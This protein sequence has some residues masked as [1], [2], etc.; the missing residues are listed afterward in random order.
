MGARL[1]DR[2]ASGYVVTSVGQD[3][4]ETAEQMEALSQGLERQI[5]GTDTDLSGPLV[6]TAPQLFIQFFLHKMLKE[7]INAYPDID[8]R[9]VATNEIVNLAKRQADVAIR[10]SKSPSPTL[11][12][13]HVVEQNVS[14]YA[15]RD[16]IAAD[17][18]TSQ[19]LDWIRFH[20]W[21]GPPKEILAVRPS[22]NVR[23]TVDSMVAAIG[24]ARSG[25][26]ATRMACF[27][28]E[29][30]PDLMRVPDMPVVPYDPIWVLTHPDLRDVP[31]IRVFVDFAT[32]W[33]RDRQS[34]FLGE[35]G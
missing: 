31:R 23:L 4:V 7:F 10:I 17:T 19:P 3:A 34:Q 28:G 24:A 26:G 32:R 1:F 21:P 16:L 14:V 27:L 9:M 8:V 35:V 30:D 29:G 5:A 13:Q 18:D 12:G 25:V 6:V 33:L 22:L 11:V 20:H 15:A 2:L